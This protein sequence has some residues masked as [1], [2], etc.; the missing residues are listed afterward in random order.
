MTNTKEGIELVKEVNHKGF[1]L[2]LDTAAMTLNEE[3]Y[4]HSIEASIPYLSHFHISE[5]FLELIGSANTNHASVSDALKGSGYDKWISIE[6]KN[7]LLADN[8]IAVE[9]ALDFVTRSYMK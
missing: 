1:R 8:V 3:S 7:N 9:R 5:P 2:H 6:M 4:A